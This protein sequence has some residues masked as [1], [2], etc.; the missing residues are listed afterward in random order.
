MTLVGLTAVRQLP[1][2][3]LIVKY[4]NTVEAIHTEPPAHYRAEAM[5]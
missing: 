5:V 1:S 4:M 2:V 3:L